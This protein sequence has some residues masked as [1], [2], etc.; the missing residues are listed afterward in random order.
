MRWGDPTPW[1]TAKLL[2][3]TFSF[4]HPSDS[5]EFRLEQAWSREIRPVALVQQDERLF[6]IESREVSEVRLDLAA[7]KMFERQRASEPEH[8]GIQ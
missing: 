4:R 6:V 1:V 3:N 5:Y 2:G 8:V 7:V